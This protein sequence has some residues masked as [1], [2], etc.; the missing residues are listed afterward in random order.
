MNK[1]IL[2]ELN[3]IVMRSET[4]SVKDHTELVAINTALIIFNWLET[5]EYFLHGEG[6]FSEFQEEYN[7]L[8][9]RFGL[10][11]I[12]FPLDG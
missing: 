5:N 1:K 12:Y 9:K 2:N 4:L 6:T 3:D 7:K 11:P 8:R 10:K